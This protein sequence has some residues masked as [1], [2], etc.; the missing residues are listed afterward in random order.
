[1]PF[2]IRHLNISGTPDCDNQLAVVLP[3]LGENKTL[4]RKMKGN[5]SNQ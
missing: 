3:W 2:R 4:K 1:L 5:K